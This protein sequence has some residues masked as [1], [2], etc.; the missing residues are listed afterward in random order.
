MRLL[1]SII[2]LASLLV[3]VATA[4]TS[5]DDLR[6]IIKATQVRRYDALIADTE[7]NHYNIKPILNRA[8]N[9]MYIYVY[10][11]NTFKYYQVYDINDKAEAYFSRPAPNR[12][13]YQGDGSRQKGRK[14]RKGGKGQQA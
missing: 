6:E 12:H 4:A 7:I 10:K 2:A 8:T 3:A 11:G 5:N 9:V 1:R 14:G 13:I